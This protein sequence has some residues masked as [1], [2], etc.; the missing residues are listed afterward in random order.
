MAPCFKLSSLFGTTRS[1]STSLDSPSPLHTSQAPNGALNENILGDNS[2]MP[3][4][5]S[6]Q[7]NLVEYMVSSPSITWHIINPSDNFTA[8]STD[9][10]SLASIFSLITILSTIT[11]I[12]CFLF[13][14]NSNSS[15]TS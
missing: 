10:A 14:S 2:S 3:I 9:P 4:P 12:V 7:A 1:T 8:V 13:F 11:S 5:W 15:F 6:G